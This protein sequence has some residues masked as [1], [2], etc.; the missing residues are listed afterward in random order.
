[1]NIEIFFLGAKCSIYCLQQCLKL[2]CVK[3]YRDYRGYRVH[4]AFFLQLSW[5]N[6]S[7][8][9]D[10]LAVHGETSH[11]WHSEV[12]GFPGVI[13]TSIALYQGV[14]CHA[15]WGL[16]E[17]GQLCA[18]SSSNVPQG[19]TCL[20]EEKNV[21]LQNEKGRWGDGWNQGQLCSSHL[22]RQS[23]S[24]TWGTHYNQFWTEQFCFFSCS[25]QLQCCF[26]AKIENG[27]LFIESRD[28]GVLAGYI[29]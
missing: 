12:N 6:S 24:G 13:R 7:H 17:A 25:L 26:C 21:H 4:S 19:I 29:S 23:V 10:I 11:W 18:L 1:M 20:L 22:T 28:N 8:R 14:L 3:L 16:R 9:D 2:G 27:T 15:R 5:K